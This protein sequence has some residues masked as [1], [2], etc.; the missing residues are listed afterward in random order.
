M[1]VLIQGVSLLGAGLI[2]VAFIALQQK[3]WRSDSS[4]YLWANLFGSL[5]LTVVAVWDRRVGFVLLES[6]WA[7]VSLWSIVRSPRYA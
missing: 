6:V 2:L 4:P 1:N 7:A 3:V 5:L